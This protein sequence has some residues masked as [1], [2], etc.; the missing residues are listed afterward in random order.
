MKAAAAGGTAPY[1]YSYKYKKSTA[2]T[3]TSLA[4]YSSETSMSFKPGAATTYDIKVIVTDKTGK[5]VTKS[6][7]CVVKSSGTTTTALTN[8]SKISSANITLGSTVTMTGAASGGTSP[9][10]YSYYYKKSTVSNWNTKA[11]L[12]TQTSQSLKPTSSNTYYDIRIV[13]TDNTGKSV[14]KLY[15]VYVK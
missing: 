15:S 3:W 12:T 2:D 14:E 11:E 13:V 1:T 6:A 4:M 7:Q 10:K 5:S 9:Y 8:N